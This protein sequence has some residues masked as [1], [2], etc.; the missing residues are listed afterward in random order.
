MFIEYLMYLIY[1]INKFEKPKMSTIVLLKKK[2]EI[3][4]YQFN[5]IKLNNTHM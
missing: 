5:K 3:V 2:T 1:I 4:L